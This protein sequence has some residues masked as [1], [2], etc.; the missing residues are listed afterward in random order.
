MIS[1]TGTFAAFLLVVFLLSQQRSLGTAMLLGSL[2]VGLTATGD[3]SHNFQQL[4]STFLEGV[5]DPMTLQLVALVSL[6]TIFAYMMKEMSM[7]K[8]LIAVVTNYLNS[9]YLSLVTIPSLI[10]VLPIPGGAIFSAPM[11]EPLGEKMKLDGAELTSLNIYFRHLWYFSF[12]YIPSLILASSLSGIDLLTIAAMHL[13][14]VGFMIVIGWIYYGRAGA[15]REE[16]EKNAAVSSTDQKEAEFTGDSSP[17]RKKLI[18]ASL[19]Y[20]V[21]LLPPIL[22]GVDFVVSLLIGIILVALLKRENFKLSMIKN[23]FNLD[24]AYGIFGIMIF[25]A[26]IE[27]SEGVENF[28]EFFLEAGISPLLL[29]LV[30]P[31][32]VGLLTGNHVGAIGISYPV[33]LSVFSGSNAFPLWHMIIFSTSYFGYMMSPFHMCNIMTVKY[34]NTTLKSYYKHILFPMGS[35]AAGVL[36]LG[37]IYWFWMAL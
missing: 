15:G 22:L 20:L 21:V 32:V 10:G 4:G 3:F 12:P 16:M 34:Y 23:G 35:S 36:I 30:V 25:R 14:I 8:D 19:P 1:I 11:I 9:A 27:N 2:L 18:N 26:F 33:V 28:T 17:P 37:G 31:F 29:A 7:L 5:H 13:P 24:L 6:V